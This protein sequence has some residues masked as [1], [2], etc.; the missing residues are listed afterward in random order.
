MSDEW[1]DSK[2]HGTDVTA[3]RDEINGGLYIEGTFI[4]QVDI[5]DFIEYLRE[6]F[7]IEE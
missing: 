6:E 3:Y 5:Y 4:D 2:N 1:R 7:G